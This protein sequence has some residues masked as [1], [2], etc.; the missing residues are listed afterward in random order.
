[1]MPRSSGTVRPERIARSRS[2]L[3]PVCGEPLVF[4]DRMM[5]GEVVSCEHCDSHL[6][7]AGFDPLIFEP[8]AKVDSDID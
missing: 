6:E 2:V 1:M 8:R 5:I 4:V 7:V 3:C